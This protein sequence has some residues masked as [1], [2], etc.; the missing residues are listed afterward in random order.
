MIHELKGQLLGGRLSKIAQPEADELLLTIKAAKGQ[1]RLLLSA[2]ASLPLL[3]LTPDNKP[4]PATAPNFCMLLRKHIQNGRIVD[5]AQPGLER[6]IRLTVEH[7]D[8]MGD[9]RR[10]VLIL[11]IMG[12][13]SNLIFCDENGLILDSIK[14]ISGLISSKREVLPGKAYVS[15]PALDK[16]DLL[17]VQKEECITLLAGKSLPIFKGIYTCFT[18]LSPILAQ[19]ICY[20]AE[21]DSDLPA[22]ALSAEQLSS[23]YM[24]LSRLA[25]RILA[26]DFTPQIAYTKW[27]QS[28]LSAD[29]WKPADFAAVPLTMYGGSGDKIVSYSTMS[30][31]LQDFYAQKSAVTHIRQKSSE[32]RKIV[33]S[34]IERNVKKYDLQQKQLQDTRN[35]DLYRVYGELLHTYG[36]Q[37]PPK[38]KSITVPNYMTGEDLLIPLDPTLTSAENAARY[39]EKYNKM[40]RTFEALTSLTES[41]MDELRHLESI[42]NS[43]DIASS[44]NDLIPIKSELIES[45]YLHKNKFE[46]KG[47]KKNSAQ[48]KAAK[49]GKPLHYL[50]SDGYSLYVGKNNYQNDELTFRFAEGGDWWFHAKGQPGSHVI[51][52][53][54]G[55]QDLPDRVFEEA[56]CLAAYYSKGREQAKVE[57]DYIQKKHV[58]KPNGAKPGFVVYYTNYS[59]VANSDISALQLVD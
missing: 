14:H 22:S 41:V 28:E 10:K 49:I 46:K 5:I 36:Y 9:L 19:E 30:A 6:I 51:L 23:I 13:H 39:F 8:E 25:E 40:K 58:K 57:I 17:T 53:S 1:V 34:A 54:G 21:V 4:S 31:L 7:L 59:L 55:N 37:C 24:A 20:E 56:G 32:L 43:L 18:G 15:P 42:S 52:K 48:G 44:E 2:N 50:S 11:E 3:Y 47:G 16:Q 35:R 38:A 12:K 29:S 27:K 33:Q 26:K 45:G